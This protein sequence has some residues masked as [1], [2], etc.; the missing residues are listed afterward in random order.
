MADNVY[1]TSTDGISAAGGLSAGK[2]SHFNTK[3]F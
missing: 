3:L 2:T 1:I